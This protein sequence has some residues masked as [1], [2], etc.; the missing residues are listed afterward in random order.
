MHGRHCY[1]LAVLVFFG[2]VHRIVHLFFEPVQKK[3]SRDLP[4]TCVVITIIVVV[5]VMSSCIIV[6]TAPIAI[7]I[8]ITTVAAFPN[9]VAFQCIVL[10]TYVG[11][12]FDIVDLFLRGY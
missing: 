4:N 1:R 3:G 7:R 12:M 6:I 10:S 5:V 11:S 9:L 8:V 2:P